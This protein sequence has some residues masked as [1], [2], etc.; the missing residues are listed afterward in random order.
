M[1]LG[2]MIFAAPIMKLLYILPAYMNGASA[3]Q[4]LA[5]GMLFFTIYTVSS[6]I[7]QGLGKPYLPM[8][9][10]GFGSLFDVALSLYLVLFMELMVQ[11]LHHITAFVIMVSIVWKTLQIADVKL[12]FMIL[13][14]FSG[15]WNYGNHIVANTS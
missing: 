11:R 13:Q 2:T 4:I 6:S 1:S 8:I 7:A 12:E 9:I 10:L 14:D 5:A 15:N 3:L